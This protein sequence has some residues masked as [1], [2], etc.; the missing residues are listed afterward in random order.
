MAQHSFSWYRSACV[1]A[2]F[3]VLLGVC[4]A[5]RAQMTSQGTV[6]VSVLD[7]TGAAVQGAK[8]QLQD[9]ATNEIREAE[10]Q[11]VGSYTFVALPAGTYKLTVSKTGFQSEVLDS[12]IVQSNRVTDVKAILKVGAAVEKVEVSETSTP[13]LETTSSAIASTIDMKQIEALP[14]QGRDIS[15]LA[16]L[17]PGFSGTAGNGTWGGLPVIAQGNNIDGVLASTSRMKFAGNSQ[18]GLEARLEDI[19]EMTVQSGQSDLSQGLGTSSMQVNF[20]TR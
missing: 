11:Q 6:T 10:T 13:L 9:V 3:V 12:V 7:P 1:L 15:A 17:T 5:S 18:P 2:V 14:V 16:F 8:L 4:T 20:V 19:Q